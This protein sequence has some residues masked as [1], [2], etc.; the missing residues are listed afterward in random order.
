MSQCTISPVPV[1]VNLLTSTGMLCGMRWGSPGKVPILALHGWLDNAASFSCLGPLLVNAD[2][3]AI[4]LPGH[5]YSDHRHVGNHYHFIDYIPV[6]LEAIKELG[7]ARCLLLGHSLGAAIATFVAAVEPDRIYGL[8]LID[9]LGPHS[10]PIGNAPGRLKRSIRK[11]NS[12]PK[13]TTATY[14]NIEVM[15]EARH[16][17]GQLSKRAAELLVARNTIKVN[18]RF[19]WRTDPRLLF[20]SPQYMIEEEVL[21]F[22]RAIEAPVALGIA[23]DGFLKGRQ[24]T[25]GR[26][27]AFLEI[28]VIELTGNHHVHLDDPQL[29]ARAINHFI[30]TVD[31]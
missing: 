21:S 26:I 29:V 1:S 3:V 22:L 5:G 16:Q 31:R 13:S 23:S 12:F 27:N 24:E 10:E 25:E 7:W 28:D 14:P 2:F 8:F 11:F 18:N 15:I 17:A 20:P 30:A 4:D 9:G 6:V 19:R